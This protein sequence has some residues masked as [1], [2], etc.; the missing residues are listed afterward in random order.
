MSIEC[1]RRFILILIGDIEWSMRSIRWIPAFDILRLHRYAT[2][3]ISMR[4]IAA[5]RAYAQRDDGA[6]CDIARF[7]LHSHTMSPPDLQPLTLLD[8]PFFAISSMPCLLGYRLRP[9]RTQR[10]G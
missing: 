2:S 1:Y 3:A 10:D 9:P 4:A 6:L 7:L 5:V 8:T